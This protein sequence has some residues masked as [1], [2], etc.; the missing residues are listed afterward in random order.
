MVP[1]SVVIPCFRCAATIAQAVA[2]AREQTAAALEVIA[3]DDASDD[4]TAR[5]LSE[6]V[7]RYGGQ[8]LKVVRLSRNEGPASARNAGWGAAKGDY[9]AFLDADDTWHPR[10][11]EIQY[12][13]MRG[14]P[15]IALCAHPHVVGE[16]AQVP[17]SAAVAIAE[18]DPRSLLWRNRFTPTSVM[19]KRDLRGRFPD[20]Q[21]Y[22]EDQRA[23]L[24]FAFSGQ[25]IV[26]IDLP[27]AA[28]HKPA[29]GV[30]GQ[31]ANLMA[32]E[33]AELGN[34]RQLW[35]EG[36]IK[37]PL[38]GALWAWSAAKFARRLI[39]VAL[40]RLSRRA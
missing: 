18:V 11:L 6:L 15:T 40:R 31:S 38:L 14:D 34:Y 33:R 29:Y 32:M 25:R 9:V 23:W 36:H 37:A 20:G 27:L 5:E 22:M 2:S 39:V 16:A 17:A 3:V 28:Q 4:E 13:V 26:M 7:R 30:S 19:L 24:E 1:V 35:R 10:K 21:R 12:A 8:W